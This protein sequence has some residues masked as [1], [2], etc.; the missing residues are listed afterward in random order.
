M[1][2]GKA[3]NNAAIVF[4]PMRFSRTLDSMNEYS[5]VGRMACASL[6]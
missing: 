3:L 6:N 5:T 2:N 4:D 1:L